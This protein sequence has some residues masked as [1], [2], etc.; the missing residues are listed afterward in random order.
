MGLPSRCSRL[1][2]GQRTE[3]SQPVSSVRCGYSSLQLLSAFRV[4]S[5]RCTPAPY[6]TRRPRCFGPPPCSRAH[7]ARPR[8]T[9]APRR[10]TPRRRTTVT[11]L[12]G[13][14]SPRA[15]RGCL[16]NAENEPAE[17]VRDPGGILPSSASQV[18][19]SPVSELT[20][21]RAA[22][23]VRT[24]VGF[25]RIFA[26]RKRRVDDLDGT[27]DMLGARLYRPS[28]VLVEQEFAIHRHVLL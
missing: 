26:L 11:C 28:V 12:S 14:R 2:A 6:E 5:A 17:A 4:V 16:R 19:S 9:L 10:A 15:S 23:V 27:G 7:A 21:P 25:L 1:A 3:R 20:A 13:G 18:V 24:Y 8:A 22:A